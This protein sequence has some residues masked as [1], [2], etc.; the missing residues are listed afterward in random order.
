MACEQCVNRLQD[1]R[2]AQDRL[3]R[4]THQVRW[5]PAL[6][7]PESDVLVKSRSRWVCFLV[8]VPAGEDSVS[9]HLDVWTSSGPPLDQSELRAIGVYEVSGTEAPGLHTD[10]V[11]AW[12]TGRGDR[13]TGSDYGVVQFVDVS[14]AQAAHEVA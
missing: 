4:I 9:D 13:H 14:D 2:R 10:R 3:R 8:G 1:E 12:H 11:D 7:T 6:V 5:F